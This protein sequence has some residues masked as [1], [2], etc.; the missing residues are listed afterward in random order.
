M[1]APKTPDGVSFGHPF[2]LTLNAYGMAYAP[3]A[4]I[5]N[6]TLRRGGSDSSFNIYR[7]PLTID[8]TIEFDFLI[9]GF[10]AYK[11]DAHNFDPHDKDIYTRAS[12]SAFMAEDEFAAAGTG[13]TSK[14]PSLTTIGK[15]VQSLQPIPK[16]QF[17]PLIPGNDFGTQL[18]SA[19]SG[20]TPEQ[21]QV[22]E[23]YKKSQETTKQQTVDAN[24][25]APHEDKDSITEQ[26]KP[27][28]VFVSAQIQAPT[29][30]SNTQ[31]NITINRTIKI[32]YPGG[33]EEYQYAKQQARAD[34]LQ[35]LIDGG[36]DQTIA[37]TDTQ[38]TETLIYDSVTI[39]NSEQWVVV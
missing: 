33:F 39:D 24:N 13:R 25:I 2:T 35:A 32:A 8:V 15:I 10:A 26:K 20:G 36:V 4:A 23:T 31:Q 34:I 12:Q 1:A 37:E 21:Q 29:P 38:Y 28:A 30:F 11:H 17:S 14:S 16:S 5:K 9:K 18:F 22:R 3:L 19:E 7:Q 6:I 27:K